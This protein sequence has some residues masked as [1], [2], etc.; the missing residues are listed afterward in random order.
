MCTSKFKQ[1]SNYKKNP[2]ALKSPE[3]SLRVA[4]GM[5]GSHRGSIVL[6]LEKLLL[7]WRACSGWACLFCFPVSF[8]HPPW[9]FT[10]PPSSLLLSARQG[11]VKLEQGD[12]KVFS[13]CLLCARNML[14]ALCT[15]RVLIPTW[16]TA[17]AQ[18]HTP[19]SVPPDPKP[20]RLSP[21]GCIL[22][23]VGVSL[24]VWFHRV[25]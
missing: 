12:W 4:K 16:Q 14:A 19:Q 13:E 10:Y 17:T 20:Y 3:P 9:S 24:N 11:E 23:S 22:F 7:P 1:N 15:A 6:L 8:D 25:M 2:A 21:K 5:E 18:G